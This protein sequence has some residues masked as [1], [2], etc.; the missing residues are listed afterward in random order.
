MVISNSYHIVLAVGFFFYAIPGANLPG[1]YYV[2]LLT[3]EGAVKVASAFGRETNHAK[4]IKTFAWR[5]DYLQRNV[6]NQQFST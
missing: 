3:S 1:Q 4:L 2:K 6:I 5:F